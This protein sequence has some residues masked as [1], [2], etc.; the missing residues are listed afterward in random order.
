MTKTKVDLMAGIS[1]LLPEGL[2]E[3]T[4]SQIAKLIARK[5]DEEVNTQIADLTVKVTSFI[6][7]NVEKLKEQAQKELELENPTFRNAQM[8][9]TVKA[10]FAVE[11][12]AD[13]DISGM[14]VLA[15]MGESQENKI[16]VLTKE[17]DK[18]LREN[19]QLKR[20]GKVLSEQNTNLV[21]SVTKLKENVELV[22]KKAQVKKFSDSAV[23]VSEQNFKVKDNKDSE[24]KK[25]TKSTH[26]NE[27]LNENIVAA[28][29]KIQKVG[30]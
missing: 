26:G 5:I 13:D 30:Q 19:V 15:S 14:G 1:G 7:G 11:N 16:E 27:W 22:N 10:L 18:L 24:E 17:L 3:A 8:F 25:S 21:G 23:V 29:K 28:S 6:R 12:T 20:A 2:D 9:E 4:L